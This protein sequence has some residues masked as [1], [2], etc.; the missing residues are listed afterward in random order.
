MLH[1]IGNWEI[2]CRPING[3][4]KG[5]QTLP[6]MTFVISNREAHLNMLRKELEHATRIEVH[7]ESEADSE[8][9]PEMEPYQT[10]PTYLS[11]DNAVVKQSGDLTCG[12]RCLQNMYGVHIVT[13]EE[14]DNQAKFLEQ[15]EAK[16][17]E[18]VEPKYDP[19]LGDYSVE[20]L[21]SVLENK[22]KWTQRIDIH[23][24]PADYFVRVMECNPTFVGYIVALPGHYVTI[25]YKNDVY[26]CLDSLQGVPTRLID[27]RTLLQKN[28]EQ[29]NCSQDSDDV[30]PVIALLA[31]GGSPFVE[32][33]LLHNSWSKSCPTPEKYLSEITNALRPNLMRNI[34]GVNKEIAAWFT[35][36]KTTRIPP[37]DT[38]LQH[39]STVVRER[40]SNECTIIVKRSDEQC[41]VR[42]SSV[43]GLVRELTKMQW[44]TQG[45]DFYFHSDSSEVVDEDGAELDFSA[46]GS[47][48][49]FGLVDGSVVTLNTH[50][51]NVDNKAVVGGFYRFECNIEGTCIGQ[52]HNAYSI[53]DT[54]GQVHVVYK[55][56]IQTIKR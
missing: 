12:M 47:L 4:Y 6:E 43:E 26:K 42:C 7:P 8:S 55:K 52:Q 33:D 44:I 50:V 45:V 53:R 46:E 17:I 37:S 5:T 41:A 31:V 11:D 18:K 24:I 51:I 39:L 16:L 20:V 9:E 1:K 54:E 35:K 22:G 21:Q 27:R 40:I 36:W 28:G 25:K 3:R 48:Q 13:R 34:R 56:C 38:T 30:R 10:F 23:K 29:I 32:Y 2:I 49:D 14:M 19:I 15:Q